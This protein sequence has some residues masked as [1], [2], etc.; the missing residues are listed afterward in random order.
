VSHKLNIKNIK[1]Y[2]CLQNI[3][4]QKLQIH[5]KF[6]IASREDIFGIFSPNT[7]CMV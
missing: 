2:G 6:T 7:C 4:D 3:N 1:N 5:S